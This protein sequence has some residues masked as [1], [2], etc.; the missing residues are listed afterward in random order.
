MRTQILYFF[1]VKS[2]SLDFSISD[3]MQIYHDLSKSEKN[4]SITEK[5]Y[6][7]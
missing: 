1:Y 4:L 7:R 2:K 3:Q 6:K 5:R